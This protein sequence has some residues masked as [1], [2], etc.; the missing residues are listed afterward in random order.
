MRG[1]AV[2]AHAPCL[3]SG[4]VWSGSNGLSDPDDI[5]SQCKLLD[6]VAGAVHVH[7]DAPARPWDALKD[8]YERQI[9]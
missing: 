4:S 8:Q 3:A 6:S 7:G 5:L 9:A 2:A 1:A